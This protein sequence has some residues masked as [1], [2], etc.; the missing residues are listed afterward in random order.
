MGKPDLTKPEPKKILGLPRKFI[1][2]TK[3]VYATMVTMAEVFLPA[4]KHPQL[5]STPGVRTC[6]FNF[7]VNNVIYTGART[8]VWKAV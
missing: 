4:V 3:Q 7:R 5:S 1:G 8:L 6:Q 2:V